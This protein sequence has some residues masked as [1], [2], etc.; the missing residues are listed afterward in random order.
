MPGNHEDAAS[1]LGQVVRALRLAHG[2]TQNE[3]ANR[4]N[5]SDSVISRLERG[6]RLP[7]S[8]SARATI[9]L[10]DEALAADGTIMA[11][12]LEALG[13]GS[14]RTP[15]KR[16]VHNYP[17]KYNGEVWMQLRRATPQTSEDFRLAVRWGPWVLRTRA[18]WSPDGL[19]TMWHTKGDDGL[20]IPVIVLSDQPII[21]EFHVGR[22]PSE[23]LDINPG[24]IYDGR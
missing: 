16:W 11:W 9:Q 19:L 13:A 7:Q 2:L 24:W 3:L 14:S 5:T 18:R 8:A 23:A 22:P 15:A 12:W 6:A 20:S 21:A 10:L 1:R 4:A 17:A